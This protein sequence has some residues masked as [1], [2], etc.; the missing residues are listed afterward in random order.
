MTGGRDEHRTR[1]WRDGMR[2]ARKAN[3]DLRPIRGGL[4]AHTVLQ[5]REGGRFAVGVL[6]VAERTIKHRDERDACVRS[7]GR[8]AFSAVRPPNPIQ[9]P[10]IVRSL[11][12]FSPLSAIYNSRPSPA[13]HTTAV[14][15][16]D[17]HTEKETQKSNF[18]RTHIV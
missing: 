4:K 12:S 9:L 17:A 16:A 6:T 8:K 13:K 2:F 14:F 1:Y 15:A 7:K 10:V 11:P 18:I 5:G 3:N